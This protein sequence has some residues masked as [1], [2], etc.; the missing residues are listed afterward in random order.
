M[1]D[2]SANFSYH[3][4]KVSDEFPHLAETIQLTKLD[5]YKIFMLVHVF[6]QPIR[7]VLNTGLDPLHYVEN[8]LPVTVTS[9]IR[10]VALN[11]E[12][13]GTE[14]SDHLFQRNSIAVDFVIGTRNHK[15]TKNHLDT[16][17][18]ECR[19]KKNLIKQFIYYY[20]GNFIHLSMIDGTGK[21]WDRLYCARR[22][23]D[24]A[25]R[26]Y[27]RSPAEAEAYLRNQ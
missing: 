2:I 11:Q 14:N 25:G 3:E 18:R 20:D 27:F 8:I 23:N 17:Y 22:P 15:Q 12:V 26:K 13:G 4:F 16:V 9:G 24:V 10:D 5:R 7:D 19:R 1:G 6:L 21:I